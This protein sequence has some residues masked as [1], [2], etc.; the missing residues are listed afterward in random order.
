[1]SVPKQLYPLRGLPSYYHGLT[2]GDTKLPV[3]K[4]EGLVAK[5]DNAP[6]RGVL[7][8]TGT[9]APVVNQFMDKGV[10]VVGVSFIEYFES[11]FNE[12]ECSLPSGSVVVIYDI[13]SEPAK[14]TDYSSR[15]LQSILATYRSVD[16]LVLL[17]TNLTPTTFSQKYGTTIS[18]SIN[19]Q[20]KEEETWI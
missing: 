15:L 18:N 5:I 2:Y 9:A 7:L 17:E 8:I 3:T 11:R 6:E 16:T 20:L 13:G 19:L 1:M 12:Q 14:S 10:K 4:V